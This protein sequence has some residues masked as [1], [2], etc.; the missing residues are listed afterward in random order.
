MANRLPLN[1]SRCEN[2]RVGHSVVFPSPMTPDFLVCLGCY[3][4]RYGDLPEPE[5]APDERVVLVS[6]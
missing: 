3:F 2:C 4:D 5:F 1:W 6:A